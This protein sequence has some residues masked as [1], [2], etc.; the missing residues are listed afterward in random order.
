M[1]LFQSSFCLSLLVGIFVKFFLVDPV[2][3]GEMNV[4]Y[5]MSI[6]TVYFACCKH[7]AEFGLKYICLMSQFRGVSL[8]E[9]RVSAI[10]T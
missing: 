6:Y 7:D 10:V 1:M 4:Y 3:I 9:G 5:K 2:F 8:R